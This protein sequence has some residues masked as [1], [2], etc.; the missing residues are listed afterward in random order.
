MI[1]L[2]DLALEL[3]VALPFTVALLWPIT[4]IITRKV[5]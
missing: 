2:I 1:R 4:R 3:L 5:D